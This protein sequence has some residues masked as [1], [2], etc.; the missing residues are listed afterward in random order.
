MSILLANIFINRL[1]NKLSFLYLDAVQEKEKQIFSP[2]INT[3]I[4]KTKEANSLQKHLE[5]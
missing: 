3:N 5:H 1:T 4:H 2:S